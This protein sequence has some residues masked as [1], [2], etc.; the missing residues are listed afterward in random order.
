MFNKTSICHL[1]SLLLQLSYSSYLK[2]SLKTQLSPSTLLAL[3]LALVQTS[4]A[5]P[6]PVS[7]LS[8][9]TVDNLP[10]SDQ[11]VACPSYRYS[12][13]QVE[14]AIQQGI[15]TTPTTEP[16]PGMSS[17]SRHAVRC[18][19]ISLTFCYRRLSSHLRQQPQASILFSMPGQDAV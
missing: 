12:R 8:K 3:G 10:P 5:A 9:R 15:T 6:A 17:F 11:F 4:S 7:A 14:K 1:K 2:T 18:P 19:L 13:P 16:Q